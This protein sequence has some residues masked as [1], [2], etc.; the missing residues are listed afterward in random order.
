MQAQA[1]AAEES[2]AI[3]AE[4]PES[5]TFWQRSAMFSAS[6]RLFLVCRIGNFILRVVILVVGRDLPFEQGGDDR[7]QKEPRRQRD[8]PF[9]LKFRFKVEQKE[10][11]THDHAANGRQ[12]N[13]REC[14]V[15]IPFFQQAHG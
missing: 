9:E 5:P 13:A 3:P 8:R 14:C 10:N 15:G 11:D 1:V 7:T 2:E 6:L 4:Q 12:K